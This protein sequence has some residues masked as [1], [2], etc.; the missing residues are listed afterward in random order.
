MSGFHALAQAT[1]DACFAQLSDDLEALY[2]PAGSAVGVPVS[3]EL[4]YVP[5]E[6]EESGRYDRGDSTVTE[7]RPVIKIPAAHGPVA[8]GATALVLGKLWTVSHV[9]SDDGYVIKAVVDG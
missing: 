9:I 5:V 4:D 6:F 7:T 8:R 2:T 1:A 3:V